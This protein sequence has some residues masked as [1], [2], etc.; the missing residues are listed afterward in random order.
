MQSVAEK[1]ASLPQA[2]RDAIIA[3]LTEHECEA[4]LHDWRG[5]HARPEQCAPDGDWDIWLILSGRGWGKTRTGA[6]WIREKALEKPIRIALIGET[7]A[8]ARDV[9]VEGE[10]GILRCHPENERPV[11]EPS[12]RR[13]TW[14]NGSVATLFNAT[15]PDQLRGPQQHIAWCFIAGTMVE[16]ERGH[17]PIEQVTDQD[18]V[19][20]M[21]GW[22]RV[23]C[24]GSR[25]AEVGTVRF[26]TGAVLTGTADH[27]VLT[28]HGETMWWAALSDLT[29]GANVC[30]R[31]VLNGVES[32]GTDTPADT[33]NTGAQEAS[34]VPTATGCT[35][36][37]GKPTTGQSRK[38]LTF[39][40][41]TRTLQTTL[42][43]TF[44]YCRAQ[45]TC[46]TTYLSAVCLPQSL[47]PALLRAPSAALKLSGT[48]ASRR[49]ASAASIPKP[50]SGER[51]KGCARIVG[52]LS[53]RFGETIA[54][55]V[56][57]TW[58]P[59]GR[60]EVFCL[61]VE[62]A[63]HYFANGIAVHN[64]DELAKWRYARETWDQ[65]QF[66]L[67]LG[68]HPQVLVTTTP[69]PIELVKAIV[70]GN[71]GKAVITRGRTMD[72][73]NNLA[74]TFLEKIENRYGGTR[75]GRQELEGEILGDIPNA[76]WTLAN[77]DTS[78][79]KEAP[80]N[81]K[82]IYV[83]IDPAVSNT[84][85]S[86]E[87]G[88]VAVGL[89]T[90]GKEG[91]VLEDA[92]VKGTPMEWAKRA[93]SV[94]D[95]LQADG[96]VVEVNQ[97][98]DMVAQTIR[99]V[100]AGVKIIEVRA[101][102]GKHVRAEP[103]AALYEQGRIHHVGAFIELETQMT[104]MTTFGYEGDGS[105]DRVDALVWGL[106]VLFPS[107]VR[108]EKARNIAPPPVTVMPMARR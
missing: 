78:R 60:A 64:C 54:A 88:I 57:S 39:T 79:V 17:V 32:A 74:G 26:S 51:S 85:E 8:D 19:M 96:I 34:S 50:T 4:L 106:S 93:L 13:L 58:E 41:L 44:S 33:M 53:E 40:T 7:A 47:S 67:R 83:A 2:D 66:G 75:L 73:R 48:R 10:S 56:A 27:P 105:P 82:R 14:P 43:K 5:F 68:D 104:Q 87:H 71:E 21:Q 52:N 35:E 70:A 94:H 69:R 100:R 37:S 107:M 91:Y 45:I 3:K 18:R 99:S 29:V 98:G 77:I 42:S 49:S 80:A 84:E 31:P 15:E 72:N 89:S 38:G 62:D 25:I 95:R 103:I 55:S 65:L 28:W 20:T 81:L 36:P 30:A 59:A 12:K 22:R 63:K 61:Q 9:M 97:G 24:N 102:R 1:L 6:E 16:T 76:L 92:S 86:D 11:Y 90:D 23:Q 46:A 101:S 108:E